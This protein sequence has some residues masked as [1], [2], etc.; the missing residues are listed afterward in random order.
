MFNTI[1]QVILVLALFIPVRWL[2]YQITEVWGL[3]VWLNY[4]PWSCNLCL[5]FWSLLAV[6]LTVGFAFQ[7]WIT[8]GAGLALTVLNAV[9]MYVNQKNKTITLDEYD[10]LASE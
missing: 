9:A 6:Y 1:L 8:M 10:K 2:T 5:T 4:R 7:L 3:P